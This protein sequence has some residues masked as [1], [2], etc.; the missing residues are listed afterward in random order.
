MIFI[1]VLIEEVCGVDTPIQKSATNLLQPHRNQKIDALKVHELEE[2]ETEVIKVIQ[3]CCFYDE[4]LSLQGAATESTIPL[5]VKSVK[6]SS[7]ICKLDP[8]LWRGLM[9][10][11]SPPTLTDQ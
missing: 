6:K 10:R 9:C 2:A 8:V 7:H 4:L 1:V 3:T 5:K 11:R